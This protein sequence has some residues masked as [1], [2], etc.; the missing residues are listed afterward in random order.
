MFFQILKYFLFLL[1]PV[2]PEKFPFIVVGNKSDKDDTC[3]SEDEL[4]EYCEANNMQ[5]FLVSAKEGT[6]I[7]EAF[8]AAI[9]IGLNAEND[10]REFY[11][12]KP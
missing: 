3:V 9:K 8:E 5:H 4:K 11:I 12:P 6:N 1:K 10:K 7:N 2:E